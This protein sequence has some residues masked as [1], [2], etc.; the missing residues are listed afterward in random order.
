[1]AK[2]GLSA[3]AAINQNNTRLFDNISKVPEH[4]FHYAEDIA[5]SKLQEGF[6]SRYSQLAFSGNDGF[7]EPTF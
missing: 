2:S 4:L 5:R 3:E 1:V 7:H 6:L